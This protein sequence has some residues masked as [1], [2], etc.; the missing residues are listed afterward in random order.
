MTGNKSLDQ[1]LEEFPKKIVGVLKEVIDEQAIDAADGAYTAGDVVSEDNCSTTSPT[2]YWE[3][4]VARVAGG[5]FHIVGAR[6]FNDTENQAVQ[7]DLIL[8]SVAPTGVKTDNVANTNPVKGDRANWLGVIEFPTSVAKGATVAT[9]AEATPST[10]GRLPKALK[11]AV[12]D[13][14]IYAVLVTNTAYTQT[15][16]DPIRIT[17]MVEQY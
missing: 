1:T 2:K 10:L 15:E 12:G 3:F 13:T 14:K 11:C 9:T 6:L 16:G 17:L 4:D 8:F 5:Y 7:Y